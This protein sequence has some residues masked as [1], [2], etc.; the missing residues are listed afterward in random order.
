MKDADRVSSEFGLI[1]TGFST[2][3]PGRCK[4]ASNLGRSST[5]MF[6]R[7]TLAGFPTQVVG[8]EA[9]TMIENG[10]PGT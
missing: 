3:D 8:S 4:P 2:L 10:L 7:P 6:P 9:V 1:F 5:G